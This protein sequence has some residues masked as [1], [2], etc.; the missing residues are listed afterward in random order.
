MNSA[1]KYS[2]L[3]GGLGA[4]FFLPFLGGVHLFDWD[5]INFAEIS[6]E[7]IVLDEYLRI[8]VNFQPFW[9]KPP[10]FF[11]LQVIAMNLFGIGEYAARFPNAICGIITLIILFNIGRKLYNINFGVIWAGVYLGSILPHLYFKSG[12]IDPWFNLFIFLGEYF[13]ILFYWKKK[14]T[15]QLTLNKHQ[16]YYLFLSGFFIGMGILTKGPVSFLIAGLTIGVYWTFMRFKKF[17]ELQHLVFFIVASSLV[18]LMWY[19][20]ETIMNSSWFIVEFTKYQ[21]R[22]FSTPDAGHKGFFAYHFIVLLIGCFPASIFCIRSF[23]RLE[24]DHDYQKDFRKWMIILFWVVLILF[25]IV[26]SKIVH[27]SSM[28]YFPLT[29]L[30]ALTIHQ[31]IQGKIGFNNW[32]KFGLVA[33]ALIFGIA[34]TAAPFIGQNIHV[35]KPLLQKDPFAVANLGAEVNWTGWEAIAGILIVLITFLAIYFI[36]KKQCA[37]GFKILF[38]GTAIYVLL[39]LIFFIA[40]IEKY[41]QNAAIEFYKTLENKDCYATPF[42]FRTYGHLFYTKKQPSEN[43]KAYDKNWLL[44]GDIDKDVFIITKIHKA[45][46]LEQRDDLEKVGEKNGFVFFLRKASSTHPD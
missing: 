25:S 18:M 11:W 27:Y 5:E 34:T 23:F 12:I 10:F 40:R 26:Q 33:I 28:C 3:F 2:L 43:P 29:F 24:Q 39:A 13:F 19:G 30:A 7:M 20:L 9:E 6:R 14:G 1:L 46:P 31:I 22:L 15:E 45:V 16:L 8:Y 44:T 4:L 42:G 21:Y 38:G 36:Q 35:L 41:S 37:R 17:I 32:M